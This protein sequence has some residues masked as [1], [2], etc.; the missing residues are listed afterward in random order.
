[1]Q[2]RQHAWQQMQLLF[3]NIKEWVCTCRCA[4]LCSLRASCRTRG[5]RSSSRFLYEFLLWI[6]LEGYFSKIGGNRLFS[7]WETAFLM[8]LLNRYIPGT[9][10]FSIHLVNLGL[11]TIWELK[12]RTKM[13]IM[14]KFEPN[15]SY[16]KMTKGWRSNLDKLE[17]FGEL[18]PIGKC[19]KV[20]GQGSFSSSMSSYSWLK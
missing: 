8:P 1:M 5:I 10:K 12:M 4:P 14:T 11:P 13:I 15:V 20:R 6:H 2:Q 18:Y 7:L 16:D 19:Q 17:L 9:R 3:F